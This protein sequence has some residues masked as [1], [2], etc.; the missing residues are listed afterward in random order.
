MKF[1]ND[2]TTIADDIALNAPFIVAG[3]AIICLTIGGKVGIPSEIVYGITNI[4]TIT[5]TVKGNK[6]NDSNINK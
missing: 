2:I 5:A 6:K 1:Q 3:V 4:A